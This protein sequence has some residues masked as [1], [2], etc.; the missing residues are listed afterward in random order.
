MKQLPDENRQAEIIKQIEI[1]EQK[2]RDMA[3][4]SKEIADKWES[5]LIY[6]KKSSAIPNQTIHN[7]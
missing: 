7:S 4:F 6:S 1:A 5:K 2:S 3:N